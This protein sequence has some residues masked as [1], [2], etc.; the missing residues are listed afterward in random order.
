MVNTRADVS[1]EAAIAAAG[2]AA[3]AVI[4]SELGAK[5]RT[6]DRMELGARRGRG[7]FVA[8][9]TLLLVVVA[10]REGGR[11]CYFSALVRKPVE[12]SP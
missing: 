2:L 7:Y 1:W 8:V 11:P 3:L 12:L 10:V 9:I 4:M 6:G 5:S